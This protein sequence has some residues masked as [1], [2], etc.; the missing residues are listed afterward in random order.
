M[1]ARSTRGCITRWRPRRSPKGKAKGSSSGQ[2]ALQRQVAAEAFL[3]TNPERSTLA[4][5]LAQ[6]RGD[7]GTAVSAAE[8]AAGANIHAARDAGPAFQ[9][10]YGQA[11][12]GVK[13]AVAVPG[14]DN[15]TTGAGRDAAQTRGHLAEMLAQAQ[16]DTKN[17]ELTAT[18]GRQY[19]VNQANQGFLKTADSIGSRLRA[20]AQEEGTYSSARLGELSDKAQTHKSDIAQKKADRAANLAEAG[21]NPDGTIITGGPKDPKVTGKDKTKPA[22][23]ASDD[24]L[25]SLRAG[26]QTGKTAAAD[27]KAAKVSRAE[28][29]RLLSQG[30][31]GSE[32]Q[33]VFEQVEDPR[34]HKKVNR[35]KLNPDG[36][37]VTTGARGEIPKVDDPLALSIALDLAYDGGISRENVK[38]LI[39]AHVDPG[40]FAASI[41]AKTQRQRGKMPMPKRAP[42]KAALSPAQRAPNGT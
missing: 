40:V 7:R 29:A 5:Q 27:L 10:V 9:K 38:K 37:Q 22:K 28:A 1:A 26:A 30:A 25:K 31:K 18:E 6:A 12:A 23:K 17:R 14:V 2:S 21:V 32:G 41:G 19:A 20:L 16:T 42:G 34:T 35:R 15:P 13:A 33:P 39:A 3:R 24:F 8:T 11:L 36:T 4:E